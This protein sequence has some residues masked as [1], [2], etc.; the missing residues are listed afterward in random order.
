MKKLKLNLEHLQNAEVLTRSQLKQI[1][2]GDGGSGGI[3]CQTK[4]SGYEW[5][6]KTL[7]YDYG[8]STCSYTPPIGG[9]PGSC[10]C[11]YT[12]NATSCSW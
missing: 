7:R 5:N 4:C 12:V 10:D 9:L 2:G 3:G 1:L 8:T 11:P 6:P